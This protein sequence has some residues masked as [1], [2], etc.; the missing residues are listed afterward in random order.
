VDDIVQDVLLGFYSAS[1]TFQYDPSKGRFRSFLKTC[2]FRALV[3][4]SKQ[5]A[6]WSGKPLDDADGNSVEVQTA[7]EDTWEQELLRRALKATR[8]RYAVSTATQ[9]T[10]KPFE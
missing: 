3:K 8:Q 2:T 1:G 6:R 10:R 5:N 9:T 7:W 4:R